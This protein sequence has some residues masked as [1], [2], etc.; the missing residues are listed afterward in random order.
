[1]AV[2]AAMTFSAGGAVRTPIYQIYQATLG[3]TPFTLTTIS[4]AYARVLFRFADVRFDS[5]RRLTILAA[6]SLNVVAMIK[7]VVAD[8]ASVLIA[9][10]TVQGFTT[11]LATTAFT[12]LSA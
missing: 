10:G 4:A 2:V 1:M 12:A 8:S 5:G 3:L 11:G 7:F 6:L 9:V